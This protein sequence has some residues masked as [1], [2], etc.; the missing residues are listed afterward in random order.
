MQ[1]APEKK[2]GDDGFSVP[3]YSIYNIGRGKPE[4]L[5]DFIEILSE[6]LVRAHVLPGS[7][8]FK[9]HKEFVPMQPGDVPVT[10]ADTEKLERDFSYRPQTTL[11]E[12]ICR[13]VEW[14]KDYYGLGLN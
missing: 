10:Y 1:G 9:A 13:F 11:Q 5:L 12:G 3:P 4:K 2:D 8:D 6:E 7:F 14:Y